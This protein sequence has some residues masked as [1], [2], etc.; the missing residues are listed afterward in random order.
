MDLDEAFEAKE[1]IAKAIKEQLT[2]VRSRV[3]FGRLEGRMGRVDWM[4]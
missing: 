4:I 1:T 3:A 2:K